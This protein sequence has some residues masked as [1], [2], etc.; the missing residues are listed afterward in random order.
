M[1]QFSVQDIPNIEPIIGKIRKLL[2]LSASNNENEAQAAMMKAQE[3][4]AKYKLTMRDVQNVHVHSQVQEK[5]TAVTFTKATWK[6]RLSAVIAENFSCYTFF[7][8]HGTHQV[9]FMGLS[10][11]V[12]ATAAV[13]EYAIEYV[14][15]RVRQ[16]RR[17]YYRLGESTRGVENDYAQGFIDGLSQKFEVQKQKNTEW[18][19]VLVK[20]QAVIDAYKSKKWSKGSVDTSE[21]STGFGSVYSTGHH[22]GR[23]F[24]MIAGRSGQ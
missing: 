18:A 22:D 21:K 24:V 4:L 1:N 2:A 10:A 15:G 19:L 7:H 6:G 16:L 8:T 9:T 11:D 17:K 12:E 3:M 23:N 14:T 13:F 20:P 5:R